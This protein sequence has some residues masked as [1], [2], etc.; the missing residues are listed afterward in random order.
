M[1]NEVLEISDAPVPTFSSADD[2]LRTESA[3]GR[4]T[5]FFTIDN[6]GTQ[7]NVNDAPAKQQL[8]VIVANFGQ[9]A[10]TAENQRGIGHVR[11]V[12]SGR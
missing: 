8:V 7:A 12:R 4:R 2:V 6:L 1:A 11:F 9:H 10:Y 3:G 5:T